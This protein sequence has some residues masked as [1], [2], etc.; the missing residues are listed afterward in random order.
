MS[1]C[2]RILCHSIGPYHAARYAAFAQ[3]WPELVVVELAARQANC[4]WNNAAAQA[5]M[6]ARVAAGVR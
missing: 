2:V 1:P 3:R 5:D 6:V 4:P